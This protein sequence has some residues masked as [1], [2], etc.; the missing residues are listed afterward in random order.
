MN[1]PIKSIFGKAGPK[2]GIISTQGFTINTNS[3]SKSLNL[4]VTAGDMLVAMCV[5]TNQQAASGTIT[6]SEGGTW[7]YYCYG[8]NSLS[9][10]PNRSCAI[11]VRYT[12]VINTGTLTITY[13]PTTVNHSADGSGI[14]VVGFQGI[15]NYANPIQYVDKHDPP[16]GTA[17][18][19]YGGVPVLNSCHVACI[20][21]TDEFIPTPAGWTEIAGG[22]YNSP[23]L[24]YKC[25]AAP[26]NVVTSQIVQFTGASIQNWCGCMLEFG[27]YPP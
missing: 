26:S 20:V 7:A 4:A 9:G 12:P 14:A 27:Q 25:V 16:D 18:I 1:K 22:L 17:S 24:F 23:T 2:V 11:F 5:N 13:A 19:T 8:Y 3:G 15:S 10:G 21:C 6:D